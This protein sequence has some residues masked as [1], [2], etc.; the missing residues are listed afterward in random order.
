MTELKQVDVHVHVIR[1]LPAAFLLLL[2]GVLV[3][4]VEGTTDPLCLFGWV[5]GW[6]GW[7]EENEAVRM[8]YCELGIWVGGWVG[9]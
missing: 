3:T 4:V 9:G 7:V 8:S 1:Q 5:G 6:V 2:L